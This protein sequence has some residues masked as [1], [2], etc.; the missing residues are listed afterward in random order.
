VVAAF[1]ARLG[2]ATGGVSAGAY[3][4]MITGAVLGMLAGLAAV[5]PARSSELVRQTVFLNAL[6]HDY[7]QASM[8]VGFLCSVL[9][10]SVGAGVGGVN[11]RAG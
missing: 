3:T 2:G 1:V 10:T 7:F 11:K 6:A 8:L 9:G 4:G 5:A